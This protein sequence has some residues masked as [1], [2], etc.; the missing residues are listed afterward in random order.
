MTCKDLSTPSNK[1]DFLQ[2]KRSLYLRNIQTDEK[3][4]KKKKTTHK[5]FL[6]DAFSSLCYFTLKSQ[7]LKHIEEVPFEK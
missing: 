6:K 1:I 3:E 2:V 5:M 7:S 4:R